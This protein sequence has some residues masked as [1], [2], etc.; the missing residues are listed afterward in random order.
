MEV[1]IREY[2]DADAAGVAAM[3]NES[4]KGWPAGF[5]GFIELTERRIREKM[6]QRDY[7]SVFLAL[8]GKKVV[9]Y[10]SV[11][12]HSDD[13]N[14]AY[15]ELLNVH[16]KYHGRKIGKRLLLAAVE[17]SIE[18]GYDRLD[19]HTWPGNIKAVPLYKKT[20]FFWVP[21]T[22]VYMQNFIPLVFQN[23][24]ARRFFESA[25]WYSAQVRDLSVEPDRMQWQGREVFSYE[26][27]ADGTF[28]KVVIDKDARGICSLETSQLLASCQLETARPIIGL[29]HKVV[30]RFA[31]RTGRRLSLRMS[32]QAEGGIALRCS[33]SFELAR[34]RT[35][36]ALVRIAA[37]AL[38]KQ[39]WERAPAIQT[40]VEIGGEKL[41]LKAG[42]RAEYAIELGTVP[43]HISVTPGIA[44]RVQF[45]CRNRLEGP[46]EGRIVFDCPAG[47][48]LEPSQA[49]I[50]L[51]KD[52]VCG[53]EVSAKAPSPGAFVVKPR[54]QGKYSGKN[55]SLPAGEFLVA[56]VGP[57][58]VVAAKVGR[59]L[60]IENQSA[61]ISAHPQRGY[62]HI[63]L[64]AERRPIVHHSFDRLGEPF[65]DEFQR[66]GYSA[67]LKP[68]RS[69]AALLMSTSSKAFPGFVVT[70]RVSMG[71]GPIIKFEYRV[72]NAGKRPR[73][74]MLKVSNFLERYLPDITIPLK[75][76]I[77][78]VASSDF[79]AWDMDLPE[80]PGDYAE[81]WSAFHFGK[82][83]VAGLVWQGAARVQFGESKM[84][85]LVFD[86]GRLKPGESK[87]L[88][89]IYLYAG[90]GDFRVV[91]RS[92]E[93][94]TGAKANERLPIAE[95]LVQVSYSPDPVLISAGSDQ[96]R[97]RLTHPRNA[98][99]EG[100]IA[101]SGDGVVCRPER[102]RFAGV[103][104]R[105]PFEVSVRV[106]AV[107]SRR[108]LA[109][110]SCVE[111][112][113]CTVRSSV[114]VFVYG[115]PQRDPVLVK[116]QP[117]AAGRRQVEVSNGESE[118][119]VSPDFA[120]SLFSLRRAGREY[121]LSGFPE[122]TARSWLNPWFGGVRFSVFRGDRR[123]WEE[124]DETHKVRFSCASC[125]RADSAGRSWIGARLRGRL[126]AER[127]D[128]ILLSVEYL[129]LPLTG[130][131]AALARL[132]NKT[133]APRL[134]WLSISC[135]PSLDPKRGVTTW[136]RR[137]TSFSNRKFSEAGGGLRSE[138]WICAEDPATGR[139][140]AVVALDPSS[141]I[142]LEDTGTDGHCYI[143]FKQ[144]VIPPRG[145][146]STGYLLAA[147]ENL[148]EA[149]LCLGLRSLDFPR[150]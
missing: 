115:R 6:R 9:G 28:L 27:R 146:V 18:R 93:R 53:F 81:S 135:F 114:P 107:S 57:C 58:D 138:G 68:G 79:P 121:L 140:L 46:I 64:A 98:R 109:L 33:R 150:L 45:G 35:V 71:A 12:E 83:L 94:L 102:I 100:T 39:S 11:N 60:V 22:Q 86:L 23:P 119:C 29:S 126:V 24:I 112:Q 89:P 142:Y 36:E 95:S 26:W 74:L 123:F 8:V 108:V 129:T 42:V 40:Q 148:A 21:K 48:S 122:V 77:L 2:S 85:C 145:S 82:G 120:G 52:A 127:L 7:V 111:S 139:C 103:D 15:V 72:T 76:S 14:V 80:D 87:A 101:L 63:Y 117:R 30:W 92:W 113:H 147:V 106:K 55:V 130:L 19:L 50:A 133:D 104:L 44:S 125:A 13:P 54:L 16:P 88:P 91:R 124:A 134:V 96:V 41:V 73:A 69:V 84:P 136:V 17:K 128:H 67:K 49:K 78:S 141:L 38:P 61:R 137:G 99:L 143:S 75:S 4:N 20:G 32:A 59:S 51:A 97:L 118:F 43:L 132:A 56:S 66:L 10:C 110:Q 131:V 3:W 34:R 47:L 1:T 5:L 25:N 149:R 90:S 105:D 65:S 70:K 116:R 37:G 62:L 144:L 31:N